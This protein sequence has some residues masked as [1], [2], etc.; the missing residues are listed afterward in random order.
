MIFNYNF[1][2]FQHLRFNLA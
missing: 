2:S 1:K